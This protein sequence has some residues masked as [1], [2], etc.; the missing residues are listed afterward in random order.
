[1]VR[2]P[3]CAF[4]LTRLPGPDVPTSQKKMLKEKIVRTEKG[5]AASE[6]KTQ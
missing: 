3:E 5:N 2:G 4:N 6:E 1:M